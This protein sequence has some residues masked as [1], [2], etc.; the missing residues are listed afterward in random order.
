MVLR[1]FIRPTGVHHGNAFKSTKEAPIYE[2]CDVL[3]SDDYHRR[4]G[5]SAAKQPG[6]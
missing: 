5:L 1:A 2:E 6:A 4:N 3:S